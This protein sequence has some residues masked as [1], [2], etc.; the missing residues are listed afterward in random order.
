MPIGMISV[1]SEA[2]GAMKGLK[3]SKIRDPEAVFNTSIKVNYEDAPQ[4][5]K[6]F[7]FKTFSRK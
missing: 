1:P 7:D 6:K 3:G 2:I 5:V 4:D